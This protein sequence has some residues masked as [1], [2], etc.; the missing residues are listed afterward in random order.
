MGKCQN[1]NCGLHSRELIYNKTDVPINNQIINYV[2][3]NYY[4]KLKQKAEKESMDQST[5]S[6]TK[7][8]RSHIMYNDIMYIM[9]YKRCKKKKKKL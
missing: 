7:K 2:N 8:R 1:N 3:C 4:Q 6:G 5:E 9:N